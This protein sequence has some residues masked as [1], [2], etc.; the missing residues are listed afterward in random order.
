MDKFLKKLELAVTNNIA[1]GELN[2]ALNLII[3]FVE[4]IIQDR[5]STANVFG[6]AILDQLCQ[7]IGYETLKKKKYLFEDESKKDILQI[8]Y[9][10]TQLWKTGGHTAVLE[11]FIKAQ[12]N[13]QHLILVTDIFDRVNHEVIKN[14]F[15]TL[16]VK[17]KWAPQSGVLEKLIWLQDQLIV[18]QPSQVV[19]FNHCQDAVSIAAVQPLLTPN[20]V[21][22]HHCD[23]Q[24][25]LGL[26]LSHAQHIDPHPFGFYNCRNNLGVA[27]TH[28]IPLVV[29]DLGDRPLE[30]TFLGDGKLRTCSS[31]SGHKFEQ[32]YLYVYAE[33]I[34]KIIELTGGLHIHIGELSPYTLGI[35]YRELQESQIEK[36]RFIYIP[37][38]KSLW[39]A[40]HE[41]KVDIYINSFPLGGGRASIEVMGSGTPFIGH[42]NYNSRV[43]SGIDIVYPEAF[44]WQK[45]TELYKYLQNLNTKILSEQSAHS[46]KQ[47]ELYHSPS[48][49]KQ[50]LEKLNFQEEGIFPPPLRNYLT[51][52]LQ[53][54]LDNSKSD[55]CKQ[56][57]DILD[58]IYPI[59]HTNQLEL[60][61]S[62][63]SDFLYSLTIYPSEL[64]RSQSKLRQTQTDLQEAKNIILAMES[65]KFWKMRQVWLRL[66]KS[67]RVHKEQ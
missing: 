65:S 6:S 64:E 35:I 7:R 4:S 20:L 33:E 9:I 63:I 40:M 67:L 60:D 15:A 52:E 56:F 36:E 37:W 5:R 24:L 39:R 30:L 3:S 16:N 51:D 53:K 2:D 50:C 49:L 26:Y 66:K 19:L 34:P 47:Y 29:E 43:L 55:L 27:N 28:Y 13:K 22:Y 1:N 58:A 21:F 62:N 41:H 12:P 11:D 38:V 48:I 10:A 42:Q 17:I 8:I 46:R 25:C 44:F 23:H 57:I 45:P 59:L 61:K 14:R 54:F 32:S 18:N 31:G